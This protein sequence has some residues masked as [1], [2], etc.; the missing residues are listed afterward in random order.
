MSRPTSARH[1]LSSKFAQMLTAEQTRRELTDREVAEENGWLQQ[2]FSRWKLG[3]LPRRHTYASIARFLSIDEDAVS[4]LVD[5]AQSAAPAKQVGVFNT[6]SVHGVISDRKE[7]KYKFP[8]P[9]FAGK[10]IP[11]G[12]YAILIDTKIMEPALL[13][14]TKAW[15]DPS[16]WPQPGNEVMV[17]T[18]SGSAWLGRLVAIDGGTAT[19]DRA[20]GQLA[21]HDVR[22]VH[23]VVL[24]ERVAG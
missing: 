19:I 12:R 16:V 6:A 7:G 10:N 20:A 4:E 22:A 13:V 2:T 8:P 9:T 15:L 23:V 17:H 3:G 1:S 14:G 5:E 24:A 21:I 18:K 11:N